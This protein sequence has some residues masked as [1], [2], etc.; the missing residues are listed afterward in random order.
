MRISVKCSSAVHILLMLAVLAPSQR[1]TSDFLSSSVGC[2]AVEIRRLLSGLK[3]A[4]LIDVVRG[5]G[6]AMLKRHPRDISLLSI[7]S[8]VDRASLDELIGVHAHP[9]PQCPF[10][11]NIE[12]LLNEPYRE[13]GDAVREKMASITLERL[14]HR[15]KE[16]EPSLEDRPMS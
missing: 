15:L 9:A 7:Y 4:G 6:G 12:Q 10:G 2:N 14:L 13:I 5:P 11:K 1:I 3:K 8:A 16:I